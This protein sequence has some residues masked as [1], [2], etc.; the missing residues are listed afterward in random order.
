M[1]Y[2]TCTVKENLKI[3]LGV[4]AKT[5]TTTLHLDSIC[6]FQYVIKGNQLAQFPLEER[7]NVILLGYSAELSIPDFQTL[8]KGAILPPPP[9]L[10]S[11]VGRPI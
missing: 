6:K 11:A 3:V 10:V 1:S 7:S 5:L 9:P 2:S 4:G 8:L